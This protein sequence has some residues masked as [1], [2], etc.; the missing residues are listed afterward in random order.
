[1]AEGPNGLGSRR[2]RH[3]QRNLKKEKIDMDCITFVYRM[4]YLFLLMAA[5]GSFGMY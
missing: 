3:C 4:L 5:F 2:I 1:M